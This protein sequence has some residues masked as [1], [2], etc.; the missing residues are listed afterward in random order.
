MIGHFLA[1]RNLYFIFSAPPL[2]KKRSRATGTAQRPFNHLFWK[3]KVALFRQI[4][5]FQTAMVKLKFKKA[6]TTSFQ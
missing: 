2:S 1:K 4:V 5:F 6:I 3:P